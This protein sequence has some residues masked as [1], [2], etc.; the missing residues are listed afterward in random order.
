M[1]PAATITEATPC[2]NAPALTATLV[3]A[4]IIGSAV[5]QYRATVM[6]PYADTSRVAGQMLIEIRMGTARI[7]SNATIKPTS[8]P[9]RDATAVRSILAPDTVKNT[10][11]KK[12]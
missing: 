6:R 10:G 12:P 1:A 3:T 9:G 7:T 11:I 4:T 2:D 5:V 8:R